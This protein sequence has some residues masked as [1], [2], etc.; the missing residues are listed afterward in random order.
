MQGTISI[1]V[2]GYSMDL[3]QNKET[4]RLLSIL[5]RPEVRLLKAMVPDDLVHGEVSA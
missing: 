5:K 1:R 2:I 3:G 4:Q